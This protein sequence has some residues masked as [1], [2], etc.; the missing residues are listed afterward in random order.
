M[1]GLERTKLYGISRNRRRSRSPISDRESGTTGV[2][3]SPVGLVNA[4]SSDG[5]TMKPLGTTATRLTMN[6]VRHS[7]PMKIQDDTGVKDQERFSCYEGLSEYER[8]G[9]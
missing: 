3:I 4:R 1:L 5:D 7:T 8:D 9:A 6:E 2:I